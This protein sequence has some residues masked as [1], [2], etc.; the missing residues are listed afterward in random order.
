MNINDFRYM[1]QGKQIA[2]LEPRELP[3]LETLDQRGSK[4]ERALLAIHGFSSSPAV[5]RY[6]IPKIKG[7][8]AIVCPRL[9]GHGQSINAFSQSTASEWLAASRT[10]CAELLNEYQKVDVLGVSLGALLACELSKEFKLNHLF[11][12]A[13]ALKLHMNVGLLLKT[14]QLA[15]CLGF[16]HLRNEAGNII[17][18]DHAE[19]TYR[20]L[21][22]STIIEILQLIQNHQWT[23]PSCP[24]DLFLG[25]KDAVV[26]SAKVEQLFTPLAN[27][28]IHWLNNSAHVLPLDNDL[29]LIIQCIN[30]K[31]SGKDLSS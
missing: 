6:L 5:Y 3:S 30:K 27:V 29:K 17:N 1:R 4:K 2:E 21:P 28:N 18:E 14:A 12:L 10:L 26:A 19:I 8:D 11:L 31:D 7:Y 15:K 20:K 22:L 13:P 25:A 16:V 23:P 24:I 9:P